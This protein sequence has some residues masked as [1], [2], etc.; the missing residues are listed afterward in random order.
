MKLSLHRPRMLRDIRRH[1]AL[2]LSWVDAA[3]VIRKQTG[4][5]LDTLPPPPGKSS[6]TGQRLVRG[7]EVERALHEVLSGAPLVPYQTL[8]TAPDGS[9]TL[10]VGSA[11]PWFNGAGQ[12][13]GAFIAAVRVSVDPPPEAGQLAADL[14]RAT[15]EGS[16]E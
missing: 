8:W 12:L 1:R 13:A 9:K 4:G 10:W 15:K 6:W 7:G 5:G 3:G 16:D 11:E 14:I 2:V